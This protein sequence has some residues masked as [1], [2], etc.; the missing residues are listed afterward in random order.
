[1]DLTE[2]MMQ[3]ARRA[4][5]AA[6]QLSTLTSDEK[7]L[8]LEAMAGAIDDNR[9]AIRKAN[10]LDMAAAAQ[11]GLSGPMLDRLKLDEKRIKAMVRGLR[12]VAALPDPVGR[13]L[14]E[15]NRPN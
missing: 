5:T 1:M 11:S 2:Q 9:D 3:L 8:C 7:N 6:R 10:D 14:E 15:R 4:K 13:L 12:E